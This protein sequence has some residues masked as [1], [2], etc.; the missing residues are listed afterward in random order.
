MKVLVTVAFS[1]IASDLI[2]RLRNKAIL[3]KWYVKN[4]S[5]GLYFKLIFLTVIA[6]ASPNIDM[7][8]F[9]TDL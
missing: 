7:K 2:H 8:K 3:E 4:K 5:I 9:F 6:V 1:Y